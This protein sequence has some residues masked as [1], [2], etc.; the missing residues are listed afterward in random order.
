MKKS[1]YAFAFI[2]ML[3]LTSCSS[4][5]DGYVDVP[6][7]YAEQSK[8]CKTIV[9]LEQYNSEH[10]GETIQTRSNILP[11]LQVA[12]A[13]Y[14]W[15]KRGA[16]AGQLIAGL[17]GAATGGTG[18]CVTVGI[19]AGAVGGY[20]SYRKMQELFPDGYIQPGIDDA[21]GQI[22]ALYSSKESADSLLPLA[23]DEF[24]NY[25]IQINLPTGFEHLRR[26][27]NDHNAV[28]KLL[29]GELRL[30]KKPLKSPGTLKPIDPDDFVSPVMEVFLQPEFTNT[31]SSAHN[32][33][34][35]LSDGDSAAFVSNV[36]DS[37]IDA[38]DSLLTS[39]SMSSS[40]LI[41]AINSY[42]SIVESNNDLTF[43]EKECVYSSLIIALYSVEYW[44]NNL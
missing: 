33:I 4:D 20:A 32:A 3:C 31:T 2:G 9:L 36:V 40:Q 42:I 13:D 5:N 11:Y 25:G 24:Y 23:E 43:S 22:N 39:T 16:R 12:R 8:K 14:K 29:R 30:P 35:S 19:A 17:A 44:F 28:L 21:M 1:L 15:G 38:F 10:A 34:T 37:V 7:S 26:I 18:Y 6:K 41:S 27:G